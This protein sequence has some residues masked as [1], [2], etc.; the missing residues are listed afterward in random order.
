MANISAM[1]D[2][3][4]CTII[5]ILSL[6]DYLSVM[7]SSK[8]FDKLIGQCGPPDSELSPHAIAQLLGRVKCG[9][10]KSLC[11]IVPLIRTCPPLLMD[12]NFPPVLSTS[13]VRPMLKLK[14][15]SQLQLQLLKNM[16]TYD[17]L[18]GIKVLSLHITWMT[19]DY[20]EP[21]FVI[22]KDQ[23]CVPNLSTLKLHICLARQERHL[24]ELTGGGCQDDGEDDK[25]DGDMPWVIID[26]PLDLLHL[27]YQLQNADTSYA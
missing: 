2:E 17:W 23:K 9:S 21:L 5:K 15:Q 27:T 11:G 19:H 1:P 3:V 18:S 10:P 12:F 16:P 26:R 24:Y 4:L 6:A 22:L 25:W 13:T 20:V 14:D 8:L 7:T